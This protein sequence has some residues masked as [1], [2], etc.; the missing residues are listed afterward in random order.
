MRDLRPRQPANTTKP[1]T[2]PFIRKAMINTGINP[3][4]W[5][6]TPGKIFVAT[7]NPGLIIAWPP[8][9]TEKTIDAKLAIPHEIAYSRPHERRRL[10]LLP[11]GRY[12]SFKVALSKS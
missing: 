8:G 7:K 11:T 4:S 3:M 10:F 12:E 1:N 5:A 2:A 9:I 6:P